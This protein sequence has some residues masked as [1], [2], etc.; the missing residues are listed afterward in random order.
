MLNSLALYNVIVHLFANKIDVYKYTY[1]YIYLYIDVLLTH[2][3]TWASYRFDVGQ[4]LAGPCDRPCRADNGHSQRRIQSALAR[5][6][7][8]TWRYIYNMRDNQV[9]LV[10]FE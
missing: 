10:F 2:L 6:G 7:D 1:L 3:T 4:R 9:M 8:A 5:K